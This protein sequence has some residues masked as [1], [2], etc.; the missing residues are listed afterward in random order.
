MSK[1]I[2]VAK[3]FRQNAA[4]QGGVPQNCPFTRGDLGPHLI[5][6][7]LGQLVSTPPNGMSVGSAVLA[8]LLVMLNR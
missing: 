8:Q 3:E 1:L 6:G 7:S 2:Q 5:R 4:S